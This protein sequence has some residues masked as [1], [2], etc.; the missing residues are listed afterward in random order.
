VGPV[1]CSDRTR[2]LAKRGSGYL[3]WAIRELAV[4]ALAYLQPCAAGHLAWVN[5]RLR[6]YRMETCL[7]LAEIHRVGQICLCQQHPFGRGYRAWQLTAASC[8][9]VQVT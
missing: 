2:E 8:S 5:A 4:V 7:A 6:D 9:A 3:P 1:D